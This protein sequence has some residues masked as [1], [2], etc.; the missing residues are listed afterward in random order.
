MLN[1]FWMSFFPEESKVGFAYCIGKVRARDWW[2]GVDFTLGSKANE[3]MTWDEFFTWF[4]PE[5]PP[6]IEVQQLVREF[7]DLHKTTETMTEITAKFRERAFL[8][9][10]YVADEEMKKVRYHDML[11][12]NI[13]EFVSLL[14]CETQN[15]MITRAWERE[16]DLQHLGKRKPKQTQISVG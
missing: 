5:I 9:L 16:I 12:D 3:T 15:D 6:T 14:G 10:Q 11:R 4:R 8:V 2:E 7:Q 13:R 1:T